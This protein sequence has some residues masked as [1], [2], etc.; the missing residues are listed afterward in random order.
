MR[1]TRS[2][3]LFG[4][5]M[6]LWPLGCE[7][8]G[9]FESSMPEYDR[10]A[11]LDDSET[12]A[13]DGVGG[14]DGSKQSGKAATFFNVIYQAENYT[15]QYGCTQAT[16]H[17]GYTGTGFMK[18]NGNGTWIE[19]NDVKATQVGNY[20]LTFRYA[21][22][23]STRPS[24]VIVNDQT[25][26]NVVFA[27]TGGWASWKIDTIAVPLK[28]GNNT[29][30]IMAN[31]DHGGPSLDSM[32]V[33]IIDACPNDSRKTEPGECGCGVSEGTCDFVPGLLYKETFDSQ[34]GSFKCFETTCAWTSE[35]IDI[36]G[37]SK[38]TI[39][40]DARSC[41]GDN[42]EDADYLRMSYRIDSGPWIFFFD[43][44]GDL[45]AQSVIRA[46]SVIGSTMQIRV[47]A[48]TSAPDKAY[49]VDNLIVEE[50]ILNINSALIA[51]KDKGEWT[52]IVIPDTQHY[53][54]ADPPTHAPYSYMKR[55]FKWIVEMKDQLNVKMVQGLGDI[56]NGEKEHSN[57]EAFEMQWKKGVY[58]WDILINSGIPSVPNLG[59]HDALH[60][61]R[62]YFPVSKFT[63]K[64]WWNGG[65]FNGVENS[66]QLMVIGKE[67]Y[68]FLNVAYY[69]NNTHSQDDIDWVKY[70]VLARYPDRKVVL[71]SHWSSI[72]TALYSQV[73]DDGGFGVVLSNCG[74]FPREGYKRLNDGQTHWFKTDYQ[75][76]DKEVMLLRYY[77]FKP[78]EDTVEFYTY[79]PVTLQF[80]D[81]DDSQGSIYLEQIDP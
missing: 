22:G 70:G 49:E 56:V 41:R 78:L 7:T 2:T 33:A 54:M 59:N 23:G 45:S 29:I 53:V 39:M 35:E 24:A 77:I 6:L 28:A 47:E 67:K 43:H 16:S 75:D 79:S 17:P 66:Y 64:M 51:D 36:S 30:R 74:H 37:S 26:G 68:L 73:I 44:E 13:V 3:G 25:K 38:R 34:G 62:E 1:A 80:E 58:A 42:L 4:C 8:G 52:L 31:T 76:D 50:G 46:V 57:P 19:W 15:N 14:G 55:G 21:N 81:D 61:Y 20:Q 12:E 32:E 11:F 18:Y 10:I 63:D 9:D 71:A 27:N 48:Q 65:Y 72:N 60:A 40:A 5:L 69:S